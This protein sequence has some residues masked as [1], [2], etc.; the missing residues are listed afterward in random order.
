MNEEIPECI[1]ESKKPKARIIPHKCPLCGCEIIEVMRTYYGS[2]DYYKGKPISKRPFPRRF[3]QE[4]IRCSECD[5]I[6]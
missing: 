3:A 1:R 2:K 5:W 6:K 4:E